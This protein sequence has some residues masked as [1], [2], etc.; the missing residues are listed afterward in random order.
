MLKL[1]LALVVG[2]L[3]GGGA[4]FFGGSKYSEGIAQNF[5]QEKS[6][7]WEKEIAT[8]K[9]EKGKIEADFKN[10]GSQ[11]KLAQE[12][13]KLNEARVGFIT[14]APLQPPE[15]DPPDLEPLTSNSNGEVLLKWSP[16]RGAKKYNVIVED[17]EGNPVHSSEVE[18]ETYL[19]ININVKSGDGADYLARISA[20][21]GLDQPSPLSNP[22]P[23]HFKPKSSII[24]KLNPTKDSAKSHKKTFKKK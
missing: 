23:I 24:K 7:T 9:D 18:G 16:V 14:S 10:M 12:D 22:K 17:K 21:N 8:C 2:L 4:G 20:V 3:L 19:Y 13:L 11:L 15:F 1:I 5:L 6:K